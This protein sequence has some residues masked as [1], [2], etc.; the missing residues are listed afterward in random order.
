MPFNSYPS[1]DGA[2]QEIRDEAQPLGWSE[3]IRNLEMRVAVLE[4]NQMSIKG[5]CE[6]EDD[7]ATQLAEA[8][9]RIKSLEVEV[10]Y[11]RGLMKKARNVLSI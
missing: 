3:R 8:N 6:S 11:W 5:L 7:L 4:G 9:A 1:Q 2:G 10:D